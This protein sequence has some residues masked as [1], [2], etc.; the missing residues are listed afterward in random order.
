MVVW[1]MVLVH[2]CAD[3]APLQNVIGV[4]QFGAVQGGPAYANGRPRRA[5]C[6][7][8]V[9]GVY[10]G[11][12][13]GGFQHQILGV[14]ARHEHFRKRHHIGALGARAVPC[15]AGLGDIAVDIAQNRVKLG[16]CQ[17][18]PVGHGISFAVMSCP[19]CSRTRAEE[20]LFGPERR[21][22]SAIGPVVFAPRGP[23]RAPRD[24]MARQDQHDEQ[25]QRHAGR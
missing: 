19:R 7:Q 24:I 20:K 22:Q 16:Q 3:L 15:G 9:D 2:L 6:G 11:L 1:Q 17:A 12:V 8:L 10:C 21:C 23:A 25:A 14:V 18:E 4:V 5:I 13:K